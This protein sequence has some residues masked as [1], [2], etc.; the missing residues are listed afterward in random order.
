MHLGLEPRG[1]SER[2]A[3]KERTRNIDAAGRAAGLAAFNV[4]CQTR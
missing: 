1:D 2:R 4:S 3:I